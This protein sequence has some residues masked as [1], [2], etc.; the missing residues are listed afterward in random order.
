MNYILDI[1]HYVFKA[2][3][4]TFELFFAT[5]VFSIPLG[6]IVS[7][8]K[9]SKFKLLRLILSL[10]T[11]VFRGTPLLLQLFFTYY[12]L[13]IFGITFK[14]FTAAVLTFVLNYAAYLAEIFRA[15]IESIDKGQYDASKVLGMNYY[16]TMRRIIMPQAV[17]RVLPPMSSE[18]INLVKDTALVAAIGLGDL[19]RAAKEIVTRDFSITPFFVAAVVYLILT[20]FI[21]LAFKNLENK[22]SIYE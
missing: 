5:A 7:L 11:W 6:L 22:Y 12:G 3:A 16:L 18:A 21:V 15:G 20:S 8:G 9:V 14:P 13:P 1:F 4:I 2:S 17:K 19:L 10:Y